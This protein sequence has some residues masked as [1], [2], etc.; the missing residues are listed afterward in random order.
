MSMSIQGKS[1]I[2]T[3]AA[4]GVGLAIARHLTERGAQVMF[5]DSDEA[6]LNSVISDYEDDQS[7]VRRFAAW[8]R[9]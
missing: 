4:R 8:N 9:G 1:A 3:G 7:Q 2:V 6:A 5:A